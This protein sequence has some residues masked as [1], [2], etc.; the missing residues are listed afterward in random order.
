MVH[1]QD[2]KASF[3][4]GCAGKLVGRLPVGGSTFSVCANKLT[5][6]RVTFQVAGAIRA[7]GRRAVWGDPMK[8]LPRAATLP[9]SSCR[10]ERMRGRLGSDC[11]VCNL[12]AYLLG[13]P[14][15]EGRN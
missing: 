13:Q 14:D 7:M 9:H 10:T 12:S 2:T 15:V 6:L 1:H 4:H 3:G 8:N 11:D 5:E